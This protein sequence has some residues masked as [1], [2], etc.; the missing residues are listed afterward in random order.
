VGTGSWGARRRAGAGV[1]AG[2]AAVVSLF[3]A[4]WSTEDSGGGDD[5]WVLGLL[6]I[7]GPL[8]AA[9]VTRLVAPSGRLRP[10]GGVAAVVGALTAAVHVG[11]A[12]DERGVAGWAYGIPSIASVALVV[13]AV[14]AGPDRRRRRPAAPDRTGPLDEAAPSGAT[15]PR[16]SPTSVGGPPL[17]VLG[18][19]RAA[20]SHAG[21]AVLA[22]LLVLVVAGVV[23]V[24][25][26][27]LLGWPAVE[28]TLQAEVVDVTPVDEGVA[29]TFL[30]RH[31][32]ATV[33]WQRRWE[34]TGWEVGDRQTVHLDEDGRVHHDRQ[35]GLAGVPLLFPAVLVGGFGA[36]ALRRLWGLLVAV[37]DARRID[38]EPRLGHVA[39]VLPYRQWRPLVA[40]WWDDPTRHDRLPTPDVAYR[41]DDETGEELVSTQTHPSVHQAWVDTGSWWG[42]KPRWIG[43][44]A[45]VLVAHRRALLGRWQA[46][47]LLRRGEVGQVVPLRHG[48]PTV[49]PLVDDAPAVRHTLAPMVAWRLL[50][51]PISIVAALASGPGGEVVRRLG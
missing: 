18:P 20:R 28:A 30:A 51:I 40:V 23:S 42:A 15:G 41:A 9:A 39:A 21:K 36:F 2:A 3:A 44:D 14:A 29:V 46:K 26:L 5:G 1:V 8:L 38:D 22:W 33:Q 6:L 35:L 24:P 13:A 7:F 17:D 31:D 49:P 32:G 48:P 34:S 25:L 37:A 11:V 19:L 4:L 43:A 45:G 47:L 50:L 16:R 10:V 12:V 27:R